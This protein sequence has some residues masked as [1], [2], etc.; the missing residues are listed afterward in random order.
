MTIRFGRSVGRASGFLGIFLLVAAAPVLAQESE[1]SPA[2]SPTGWVFR[3][4]NFALVFG[5]I[6]YAVAKY[7]AP[8]FRATADEISRKIAEGARA[9]E[10]AERQRREIQA[11]LAGLEREIQQLRESAKRDAEAEAQR[12]RDLG[13]AEAE[14]IERAARAEIAAAG[15]AGRLDLK[16]LGARLAVERAEALLRQELAPASEATL[17]RTFVAELGRS[18]N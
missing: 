1:V 15:R 9:R 14:K 18:V 17:L 11:K 4:L 3:W 2:D 5:A 10:A 16:A 12:L 6:A 13:H 8:A 7:A